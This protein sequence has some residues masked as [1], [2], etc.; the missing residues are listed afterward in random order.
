VGSPDQSFG[1]NRTCP[2]NLAPGV[3]MEPSLG[4][5]TPSWDVGPALDLASCPRPVQ[6]SLLGFVLRVPHS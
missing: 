1:R 3:P 4:D 2:W 6:G 5:I